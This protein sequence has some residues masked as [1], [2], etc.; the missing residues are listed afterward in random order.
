MDLT[1]IPDEVD[2]TDADPPDFTDWDDPAEAITGGSTR[3]RMLDVIVQLRDPRKVSTIAERA[4]C[5]TETA[6]DYLQWFAELGMVHERSGRPVRYERNDRYFEWRQIE[7]L[8]AELSTEEIVAELA[9][10]TEQLSTYRER[11][12]ADSP[13]AVSL[14]AD[15]DESVEERWEALSEWHTLEHRAELLDAARQQ[16]VTTRGFEAANG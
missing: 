15:T 9:A 6:R 11:F 3:E 14:R 4:D 12:D 16:Q 8:R 2:T 13:A 10:V 5:D 7:R 1:D